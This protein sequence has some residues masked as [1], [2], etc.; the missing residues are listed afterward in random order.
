MQATGFLHMQSKVRAKTHSK[1]RQRYISCQRMGL[2]MLSVQ[3]MRSNNIYIYIYV[4]VNANYQK[5]HIM[6]VWC[7]C[8]ILSIFTPDPF[9]L[10]CVPT[11]F[12]P[13]FF[14]FFLLLA[15]F[16]SICGCLLLEDKVLIQILNIYSVSVKFKICI[17]SFYNLALC[18][19][20]Y[21]LP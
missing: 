2:K 5:I 8:A 7:K 15:T 6:M 11:P 3:M 12:F 16:A 18:N 4:T 17:L 9:Q 21:M 20:R 19:Q 10:R 1:V 14:Y 13:F